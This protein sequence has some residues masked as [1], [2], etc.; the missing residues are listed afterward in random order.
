MFYNT[1]P[2]SFYS[3]YES[4]ETGFSEIECQ[5]YETFFLHH[6]GVLRQVLTGVTPIVA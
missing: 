4:D 1:G 5:C 2:R 6:L 3:F